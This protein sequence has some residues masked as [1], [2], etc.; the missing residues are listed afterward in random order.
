[1]SMDE[2]RPNMN[3]PFEYGPRL[4]GKNI[5][6]LSFKTRHDVEDSESA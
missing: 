5:R 3:S 2:S 1:M 4:T 6:I